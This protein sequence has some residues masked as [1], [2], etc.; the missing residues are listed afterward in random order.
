MGSTSALHP[1]TRVEPLPALLHAGFKAD[2]PAEVRIL[3]AR[4]GD[5]GV[6][7]VEH[8]E[9]PAYVAFKC[10]DPDGHRIEASWESSQS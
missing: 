3:M 7:I 8:N 2:E 9:E 4:M 6:V 1:V 5:D 10:L